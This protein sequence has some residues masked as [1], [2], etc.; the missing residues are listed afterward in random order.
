MN[1]ESFKDLMVSL[2]DMMF[3]V[4]LAIMGN[5]DDALDAIQDTIVRLWDNR[6]L[7]SD[8][9]NRAA[10]C[11]GALR[12]QCLSALRSRR[13]TVALNCEMPLS[14]NLE[15]V[16]SLESRDTLLSLRR[17]I[18]ELPHDQKR[19]VEL[20]VFSQCSTV[21]IVEITGL[22]NQNVRTLLS[23]GRRKIKELFTLQ[24]NIR[25]D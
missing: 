20:T 16:R 12:K 8:A 10:Y 14:D 9:D 13:P 7:L 6:K 15:T 11:I 3:R 5:E 21:E 25:N 19:V 17:I 22:S 23:R 18:N 2:R 1:A 24:N 4:A